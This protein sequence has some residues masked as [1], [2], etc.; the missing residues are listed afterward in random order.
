MI[1]TAKRITAGAVA[2]L[3]LVSLAACGEHTDKPDE[4]FAYSCQ[5][6]LTSKKTPDVAKKAPTAEEWSQGADGNTYP[7]SDEFGGCEETNGWKLGHSHNTAGAVFA[8]T[9]YLSGPASSGDVPTDEKTIKKVYADGDGREQMLSGSANASASPSDSSFSGSGARL[10]GYDLNE[11]DKNH[12][13][14]SAHVET[15]MF[16]SGKIV[17]PLTWEDGDWKVQAHSPDEPVS[18]QLDSGDKPHVSWEE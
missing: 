13:T 4:D 12:V 2:G 16:F 5:K 10:V 7:R 17:V 3:A 9:D 8:A 15:D 6:D 1:Q 14:V 11:K 18:V